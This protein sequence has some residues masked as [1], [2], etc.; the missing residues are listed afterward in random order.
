[1]DEKTNI[2]L[3][4]SIVIEKTRPTLGDLAGLRY[5]RAR[6]SST[7]LLSPGMGDV[8][9]L[10]GKKVGEV[11]AETAG[12]ADKKTLKAAITTYFKDIVKNKYALPESENVTES[13]AKVRLRECALSY[14]LEFGKNICY[15]EAGEQA[16]FFSKITG[17]R[18]VVTETKCCANGSDYC[19]FNIR[20]LRPE[21]EFAAAFK[22]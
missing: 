6:D 2:D 17:K 10:A 18:F 13:N 7:I 4:Q 21:K 15:F 1:L 5:L 11:S 16:G 3:L 8:L 20:E 22:F 19:E 9:Y 12:L 14:G